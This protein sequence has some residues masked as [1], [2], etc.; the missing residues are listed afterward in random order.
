MGRIA[1]KPIGYPLRGM[2]NAQSEQVN[3]QNNR[4]EYIAEKLLHYDYPAKLWIF[5]EETKMA[6]FEIDRNLLIIL[7]AFRL[8]HH[9]Q[10]S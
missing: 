1:E 8:T 4:R 3:Q 6:P 10:F 2:K 5:D 9:W 7:P